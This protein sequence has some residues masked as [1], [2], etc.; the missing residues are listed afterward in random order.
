[1]MNTARSAVDKPLMNPPTFPRI[2]PT[3]QYSQMIVPAQGWFSA[4]TR[5]LAPTVH[6]RRDAKPPKSP[7][8]PSPSYPTARVATHLTATHFANSAELH[9]PPS[10]TYARSHA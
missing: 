9:P 8:R 5:D 1:L 2:S 6:N 7:D 3:V 4:I 10:R